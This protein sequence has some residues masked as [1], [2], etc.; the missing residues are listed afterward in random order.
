MRVP[1]LARLAAVACLAGL[2]GAPGA[3]RA[4][5][6][7]ENVVLVVNARSWASLTV[8]NHYA[9]ARR[10]PP[11]NVVYLDWNGDLE[12]ID[13]ATFRRE[14]LGPVMQAVAARRLGG[15][16]DYLVY[17]TDFP[18]RIDAR[19]ELAPLSLPPP[20]QPIGSLTGFT[21][22]GQAVAAGDPSFIALDNNRYFHGTSRAS[23]EFRAWYG[24]GSDGALLEAG[25]AR[26]M[27]SAML[28]VTTGRGMAVRDVLANLERS[29]AADGTRPPG[30]IYYAQNTDVRSRTRDGGFAAAVTE[31][32]RLGVEARIVQGAV[33][34]NA[35]DVAGAMLGT[36]RFTWEGSRILPGAFCE[37]LT[38]S[39]GDMA[40]EAGQT[41][42]TESLRAGAAGSSGA[43]V[44]PFAIAQ[45]FPDPWVHV[46]YVRGCSLAEAY[47]QSVQGPY[48]LLLVGDPLCQP[49]ARIPQVAVDREPTGDP[50]RGQLVLRP[51]ATVEGGEVVR[52]EV[53]VNG[54]LQ[55]SLRPGEPWE[56]DT[57]K[58]PDGSHE[59]RVVAVSGGPI[60]TRGR[61]LTRFSTANHGRRVTLTGAA[62]GRAAWGEPL[63]LDVE[64]PG[65]VA[66]VV[67]QGQR[68]VG[69]LAGPRGKVEIDPA[70]LG[71]GPV[72]LQAIALG[73]TGV[74]TNALSQPVELNV[75]PGRPLGP[76]PPPTV[77]PQTP[78]L[79][80]AV[81]GGA[82]RRVLT[83]AP[84]SWLADAGVLPG[85]KFALRG[86]F[87]APEQRMWQ[88]YVAHRGPLEL[89]V[90]GQT[91][92]KAEGASPVRRLVPAYLAVG[93]HEL[94]VRGTAAEPPSLT[95]L[96]G[97]AGLQPVRG[98][99]FECS[100][101]V[102]LPGAP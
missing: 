19:A 40:L 13:V 21:Y 85:N 72:S 84:A 75:E 23:R 77:D 57:T 68:P 7:P 73:P 100:A 38:S 5:G 82:P 95:L 25:G 56:L 35:S 93:G 6:G 78:G 29:A 66:V 70:A 65:A 89:V 99:P 87:Q 9:A 97:T 102:P 58:L 98:G 27:L 26:Y 88:F 3:A 42:L 8:A 30:T 18:W 101:R 55:G 37:H 54:A 17:S 31:L 52:F 46:H 80:L 15:H 96:Y 28:G 60:A 79:A 49:W 36:E 62:E 47:Y 2:A 34:V 83:T 14:L 74:A 76:L 59:L 10:I 69:R 50:V 92:Y 1:A 41:P 61:T 53:F 39:G 32:K 81:D 4:G 67:V 44:E 86:R 48:Q 64:A 16:V 20:L 33:P 71:V 45:K 94:E 90:D 91:L 22:L 43:V 51:R 11:G 63:T 24:W 12:D